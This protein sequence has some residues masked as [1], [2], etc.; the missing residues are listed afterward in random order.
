MRRIVLH[1][2]AMAYPHRRAHALSSFLHDT[3]IS[4]L[5]AIKTGFEAGLVRLHELV[6]VVIEEA[7]GTVGL[8]DDS[9]G[10]DEEGGGMETL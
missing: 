1:I 4:G 5:F 7:E 9:D 3:D 6:V 2:A 10:D 8:M